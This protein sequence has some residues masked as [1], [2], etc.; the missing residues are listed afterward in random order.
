MKLII[1]LEIDYEDELSYSKIE[2]IQS[3]IAY[4][5]EYAQKYPNRFDYIKSIKWEE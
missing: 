3:S 2:E 5:L 4:D 1:E